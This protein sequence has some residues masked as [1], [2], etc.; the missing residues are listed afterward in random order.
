MRSTCG[1]LGGELQFQSVEACNGIGWKVRKPSKGAFPERGGE[2]FTPYR[3]VGCV[4]GH[5]SSKYVQMFVW[6]R[7][8]V[9]KVYR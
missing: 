7:G 9:I 8:T 6:V 3:S 1:V 5:L 2:D 4:K